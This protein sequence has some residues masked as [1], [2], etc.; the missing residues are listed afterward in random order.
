[1]ARS[2]QA[3]WF[4]VALVA[5]LS[6]A[7]PAP[8]AAQS[9]PTWMASA[10][11]APAGDK[12]GRLTVKDGLLTFASSKAEWQVPLSDITRVAESETAN[13][14]LEIEARSGEVLS[15]AILGPQLTIESPRKAKQ[16]IER[17]VRETPAKTR[18]TAAAAAAGGGSIY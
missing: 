10:P 9:N 14:I 18:A 3:R 6:L 8:T 7:L 4:A 5:A 12:W 13:R 2:Q 17:A 11:D 15:V 16:M 1:M